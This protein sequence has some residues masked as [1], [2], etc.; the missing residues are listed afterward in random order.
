M[1]AVEWAEK[2]MAELSEKLTSA[3]ARRDFALR[4]RAECETRLR[5]LAG[6]QDEI[7][8]LAKL[9][10]DWAKEAA[11]ADAA[12]LAEER[13]QVT[14]RLHSALSAVEESTEEVLRLQGRR[15]VAR[16]HAGASGEPQEP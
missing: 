12:S 9:G 5:A 6:A 11:E 4:V 10:E 1:T 13:K 15:N 8:E 7:A 3:T 16:A 2:R 14:A